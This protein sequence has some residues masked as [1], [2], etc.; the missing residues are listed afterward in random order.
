MSQR[1]LRAQYAVLPGSGED[2]FCMRGVGRGAL[3]CV[4]DGCGGLGSRRYDTLGDHTGAFAGARLL[5]VVPVKLL[6]GIFLVAVTVI[7]VQMIA[8][9]MGISI[10]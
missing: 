4:A 6:R 7:A 2:S 1:L 10:G 8:R 3:L 5:T 9:G